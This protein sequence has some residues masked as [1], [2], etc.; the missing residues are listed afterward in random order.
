MFIKVD[1]LMKRY[2]RLLL[3]TFTVSLASAA[4]PN[5]ILV[6][7]DDQGF[8]DLGC[9][10]NPDVKT[11]AI[12]AFASESIE[13]TRFYVSP[14]CAPTR[15][16]LMTG[17]Y[18]YRTGVTDTWRGRATM[19]PDE[20]TLAEVLQ[21]AGYAT[22]LF[23]KWHLGDTYPHRPQDQGFDEVLMHR[24]G[25]I[26]QPSC[27]LGNSY[28]DPILYHNGVEV[29][30]RGYCMDVYTDA[31]LD[32]IEA[33]KDRP[34]FAY[35]ATNTPHTPLQVPDNYS[36]PYMDAGLPEET[37][38]IYGMVT[39][40]DDSFARVLKKLEELSLHENTIVIFMSDNGPKVFSP[41]AR[42]LAGLNGEKTDVYEG[43]IR[44]PFYLR[45]PERF[46]QANTVDTHAA[47]IDLMPTLLE[48][49]KI[50]H[51]LSAMDGKSLLPL[52]QNSSTAWPRRTIFLQWH[53]GNEPKAFQ[54]FTAV[55]ERYKILQRNNKYE[56]S[57]PEKFEL[58]D[59]IEDPGETTNIADNHPEVVQRLKARYMDWLADVSSSRG[60]EPLPS[61]VGSA[62]ENPVVLTQQDRRDA[63]GWGNDKHFPEAYWPIRIVQAGN[64]QM[65]M[66]LYKPTPQDGTAV[67]RIGDVYYRTE[68][69]KGV[70]TV[71]FPTSYFSEG[72]GRIQAWIDY[73]SKQSAPHFLIVEH[74]L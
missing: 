39:N 67:I 9:H 28:F 40:I 21:S 31:T 4:Q 48:A 13:F 34:F 19:H 6:L 29:K 52:M 70:R 38:K 62:K 56:A 63:Q 25:G 73:G 37:S 43:G 51:D 32:F 23:G 33:N 14:V 41:E 55:E 7:T 26:G 11:P 5:I 1:T 15:A 69:A 8:G 45:W 59:L 74:I 65:S 12:D 64:Y 36:A 10:G 22:G 27:P 2:A 17:R 50:E 60:Y 53:R 57:A 42:H 46:D 18:N 44:T 20:V 58:Y 71:T 30:T 24:G 3:V 47:H 54:N 16:S 61:W 72:E 66:E 49:C 68:I 35:L